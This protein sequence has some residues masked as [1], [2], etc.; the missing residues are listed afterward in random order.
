M[1][2]WLWPRG[3]VVCREPSPVPFCPRCG[4]GTVLRPKPTALGVDQVF[5]L[6]RYER[7]AG[8]ALRRAKVAGDRTRLVALSRCLAASM[9][10]VLAG[11]R[12]SAVVPAPSM[13]STRM[14]RGFAAAAI[15]A[16]DL[17]RVLQLPVVHALRSRARQKLARLDPYQRRRA[18]EGRIRAVREVPGR[19]LLVDDVLTT[20]ATAEACALELI[21]GSSR[22]VTL[23]TFC[24]V[25]VPRARG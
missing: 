15:L 3:C 18:L 6:E 19:V 16:R 13:A 23:V 22:S 4:P 5:S 21:G 17:G 25:S 14:R 9:G 7:P 8:Q 12:F 1:F 11:G 2:D 20:G 10:P 24:V